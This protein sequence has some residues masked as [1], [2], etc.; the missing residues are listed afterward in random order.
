MKT[1][2]EILGHNPELADIVRDGLQ[3]T[4]HETEA[5][6]LIARDET[7][8]K[9][10]LGRIELINGWLGGRRRPLARTTVH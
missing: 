10:L 4:L 1:V 9:L 6:L 2:D 7:Q 3:T 5:E 8:R